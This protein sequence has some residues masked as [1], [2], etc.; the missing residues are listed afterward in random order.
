MTNSSLLMRAMKGAAVCAA[1]LSLAACATASLPSQMVATPGDIAPA[2]SGEAAYQRLRVGQVTGGSETNPL[3]MSNVS[4]ADF[5]SALES[6]LRIVN[7]L[8]DDPSKA[9]LEITAS[10]VD[11]QRPIAG[12]DMSVTSKIRYTAKPVGGGAAV[13]D[14]TVAATGT[15]KFGEALLGV[16]RLRKAN[17]ASISA[18][19]TEFIKRLRET[20]RTQVAQE[21]EI[22][23]AAGPT[24]E[25]AAMQVAIARPPAQPTTCRQYTIK[26]VTDPNQSVC[27]QH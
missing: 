6:S 21:P 3:W 27:A 24:P 5:R 12:L 16:E 2:A 17:E 22:K 1:L 7:Y 15:A 19:I 18:N 20:L 10:I 25:P 9:G 26:V 13:Y 8:S 23:Q 11:L 14:D 4:N